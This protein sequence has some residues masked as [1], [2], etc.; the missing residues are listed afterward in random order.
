M[1]EPKYIRGKA[2]RVTMLDGCGEP[3]LGPQ[4]S[5]ASNGFISVALTANNSAP[6]AIV[7]TNANG[8]DLVDDTPTAK[9]RNWGIEINLIGGNPNVLNLLTGAPLV[10]NAD[11]DAV[12]GF[13]IDTAV[14][15]ELLGFAL[16][17]WTGVYLDSCTDGDVEYGYFLIPFA[18]GG[19][20]GNVT[21]ENA[22]INL[23]VTGAIS[24][25]GTGWGVGPYDVVMDESD[26]E[27]PLNVALTTTNHFHHEV[28]TVPPPSDLDGGVAALGVLDASAAAGTPSVIAANS[29]Y[30]A[31]M[32]GSTAAPGTAWTAG[33][34]A[35]DWEGN[36]WHWNAT[37]WI[38]GRA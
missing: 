1:P 34:Y 23:T 4:S 7:V 22:A 19:T 32:V 38:A 5:V 10:Q 37:T 17:V 12:V 28:T 26:V 16:E 33:Q 27:G 3:V 13:D 14:D 18:K 2:Y 20:I 31:G 11:E 24:K 15:V 25:N 6:E 21:F 30:N 9:F 35:V 36:E 8:V 29:Y